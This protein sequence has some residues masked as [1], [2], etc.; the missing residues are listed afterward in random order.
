MLSSRGSHGGVGS[1]NWRANEQHE[2]DRGVRG[3]GARVG[4]ERLQLVRQAVGASDSEPRLVIPVD[5]RAAVTAPVTPPAIS[6]GTLSVLS[7]SSAAIVADPERDRISIVDLSSLSH[8]QHDRPAALGT[9]RAAAW[10]T[11]RS[12]STSRYGAAVRW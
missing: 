6:G 7:D 5:E 10:R 11:R 9:S 8:P 1:G 12:T 3:D 2:R 4:R